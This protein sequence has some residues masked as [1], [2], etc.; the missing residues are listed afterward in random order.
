M[1]IYILGNEYVNVLFNESQYLQHGQRYV[2][3]VHANATEIEYEKWTESLE[4]VNGCSDGVTVDLTPPSPG[5]VWIGNKPHSQ[6]QVSII[7]VD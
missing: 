7:D 6:F 5:N 1:I 2:V 4:E 3:C